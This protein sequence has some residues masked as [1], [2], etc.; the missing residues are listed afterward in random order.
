VCLVGMELIRIS[1]GLVLCMSVDGAKIKK[2]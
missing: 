2:R 1:S